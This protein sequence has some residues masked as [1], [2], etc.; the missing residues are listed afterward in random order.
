MGTCCYRRDGGKS[1]ESNMKKLGGITSN[2]VP[3]MIEFASKY[4]EESKI[5]SFLPTQILMLKLSFSAYP[6]INL[7]LT[8][9]SWTGC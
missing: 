7:Q 1:E 2:E 6:K 3:K 5:A 4:F 9:V 8:S